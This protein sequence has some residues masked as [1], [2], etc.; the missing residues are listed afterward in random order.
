MLTNRILL[1]YNEESSSTTIQKDVEYTCI[2]ADG[3]T[4]TEYTTFALKWEQIQELA[5]CAHIMPI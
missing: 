3:Y 2:R 5:C 4:I 1:K